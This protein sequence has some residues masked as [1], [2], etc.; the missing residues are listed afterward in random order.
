LET[1]ILLDSNITAQ[2]QILTKHNDYHT[3][4][5]FTSHDTFLQDEAHFLSRQG[6]VLLSHCPLTDADFWK[7]KPYYK[8]PKF[9]FSTFSL[10]SDAKINEI[11]YNLQ[12]SIWDYHCRGDFFFVNCHWH[13]TCFIT[14]FDI[15][16]KR[17]SNPDST[18]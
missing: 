18:Y 6:L 2:C 5:I 11:N 1:K 14:R 12:T 4:Y 13:Y 8:F 10:E 15:N 7:W 17:L 16:L 9:V 3:K